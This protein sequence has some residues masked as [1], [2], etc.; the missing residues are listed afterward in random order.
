MSNAMNG[1]LPPY[2]LFGSAKV[3]A[4]MVGSLTLGFA[5][6]PAPAQ[7]SSGEVGHFFRRGVVSIDK[8]GIAWLYRPIDQPMRKALA[9]RTKARMKDVPRFFSPER[10]NLSPAL[11]RSNMGM[12]PAF[13]RLQCS[14]RERGDQVCT[15]MKRIKQKLPSDY[16]RA[17]LDLTAPSRAY[18]VARR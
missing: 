16:R 1:S 12:G 11:A 5:A 15:K 7:A 3:A 14:V 8:H 18:R 4:L 13:V 2:R 10:I 9:Y 17:L 6:S